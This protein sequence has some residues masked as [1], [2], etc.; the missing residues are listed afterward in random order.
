MSALPTTL[1]SNP[2]LPHNLPFPR[3]MYIS[4]KG[5]VTV[6]TDHNMEEGRIR[7]SVDGVTEVRVRTMLDLCGFRKTL[8]EPQQNQPAMCV[9]T[10]ADIWEACV[11][12]S[13]S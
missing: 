8:K 7:I 5:G 2:P 11:L 9:D 12:K 10:K 6:T 3:L 13:L 1:T 4:D